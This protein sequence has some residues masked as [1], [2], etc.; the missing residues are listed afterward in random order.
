[1]RE[2][3]RPAPLPK[4]GPTSGEVEPL[5]LHGQGKGAASGDDNKRRQ[6][7][8]SP[9]RASARR[10]EGVCA[11]E[12][13]YP[14]RKCAR[15]HLPCKPSGER[16]ILGCGYLN[17]RGTGQEGPPVRGAGRRT[18]ASGVIGSSP[19]IGSIPTWEQIRQVLRNLSFGG[20]GFAGVAAAMSHVVGSALRKGRVTYEG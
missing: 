3:A 19:R 9:K 11:P 6:E 7:M 8:R 20:R 18:G 15:A 2:R 12:H 1:M 13:T 10:R 16:N 5:R 4:S 17:L 14:E